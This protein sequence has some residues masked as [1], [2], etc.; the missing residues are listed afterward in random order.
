MAKFR[1]NESG[2]LIA[3][4]TPKEQARAAAVQRMG[5]VVA[6]AAPEKPK[7]FS[8]ADIAAGTGYPC[9]ATPPCSRL[10]QSEARASRHATTQAELAEFGHSA[11]KAPLPKA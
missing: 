11:D 4:L 10:L 5:Y 2:Q 7:F 6:P 8:K 3:V 9:T 1:V